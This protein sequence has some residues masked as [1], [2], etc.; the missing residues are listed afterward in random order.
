MKEQDLEGI[1]YDGTL[2]GV[3]SGKKEHCP[4]L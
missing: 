4:D 3:D 2:Y 1:F